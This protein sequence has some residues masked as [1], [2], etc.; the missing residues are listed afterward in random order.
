MRVEF[1][2]DF[3]ITPPLQGLLQSR[4]GQNGWLDSWHWPTTLALM[5]SLL[6]LPKREKF[7]YSI[8][9][10]CKVVLQGDIE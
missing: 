3:C 5:G 1:D 4:A 10:V 6:G 2:V 9:A 7:I 8:R